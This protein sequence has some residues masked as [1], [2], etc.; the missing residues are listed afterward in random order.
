MNIL[1]ELAPASREESM[2]AL[3]DSP[4]EGAPKDQF[5]SAVDTPWLPPKPYRRQWLAA[6]Y[7]AWRF[8]DGAFDVFTGEN[9]IP[10]P[11]AA[12]R[13][14][15]IGRGWFDQIYWESTIEEGRLTLLTL[16]PQNEELR[17]IVGLVPREETTSAHLAARP[18]VFIKLQDEESLVSTWRAAIDATR[19]RSTIN[20]A[21][22]TWA[23]EEMIRRSGGRHPSIRGAKELA[24]EIGLQ[25]KGKALA[26]WLNT[27]IDRRPRGRPAKRNRPE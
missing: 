17:R 13:T 11:R 16:R 21:Y 20:P 19:E 10:L 23:Q 9:L 24:Q 25:L 15:D 7:I 18:E 26:D 4:G 12:R 22:L 5:Q 14:G 1:E 2:S 3:L 27:W 6:S 8:M